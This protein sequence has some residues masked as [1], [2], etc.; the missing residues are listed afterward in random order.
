[1]EFQQL[2]TMETQMK[3]IKVTNIRKSNG[4]IG[5]WEDAEIYTTKSEIH[6]LTEQ[7]KKEHDCPIV[8]LIYKEPKD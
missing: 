5:K 8:D 1:M 6:K 2:Y 7:L 4:E 3:K